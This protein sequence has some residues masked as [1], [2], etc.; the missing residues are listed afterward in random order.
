MPQA[1][2]V[3]RNIERLELGEGDGLEELPAAAPAAIHLTLGIEKSVIFRNSN[4][5][6]G[7]TEP[8]ITMK[9]DG[10]LDMGIQGVWKRRGGG[11]DAYL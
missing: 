10:T 2:L 4:V 5:A 1:D 7:G 6:E 8:V 3:V 9:D 11:L